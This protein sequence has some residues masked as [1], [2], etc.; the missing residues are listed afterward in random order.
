MNNCLFIVIVMRISQVDKLPL[1]FRNGGMCALGFEN[2]GNNGFDLAMT[3]VGDRNDFSHRD[4]RTLSLPPP[5]L[6]ICPSVHPCVHPCIQKNQNLLLSLV[7]CPHLM[8]FGQCWC[9]GSDGVVRFSI[10]PDGCDEM[11]KKPAFHL[12]PQ[13]HQFCAIFWP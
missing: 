5:F 10:S 9:C 11:A 2:I 13:L 12:F 4:H 1:C 6:S 8:G 7:S 3:T